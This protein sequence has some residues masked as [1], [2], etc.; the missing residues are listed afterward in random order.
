MVIFV[1]G[2]LALLVMLSDLPVMSVH[3]A[4][5][6]L[7]DSIDLAVD[8]TYLLFVSGFIGSVC[9]VNFLVIPPDRI[10]LLL[11]LL[12]NP[13]VILGW[14]HSPDHQS[15]PNPLANV[16]GGLGAMFLQV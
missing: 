6:V 1:D 16:V 2:G 7:I 13:S 4:L 10:P 8:L 12:P 3:H 11:L 5:V 15:L 9:P 14:R